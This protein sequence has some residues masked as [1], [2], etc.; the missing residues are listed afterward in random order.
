[1]GSPVPM[2]RT[3][4]PSLASWRCAASFARRPAGRSEARVTRVPIR[5]RSVEAATAASVAK[6][7]SEGR[8]GEAPGGKKWS[9][10]KTPS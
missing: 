2:P 9:K 7:S 3:N 10:A 5:T 8:S 4:R 6:A 1:M